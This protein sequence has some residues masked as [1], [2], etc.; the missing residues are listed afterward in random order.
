[1]T[2]FGIE[3]IAENWLFL[4][5]NALRKNVE[6]HGHKWDLDSFVK[7]M[8]NSGLQ[9]LPIAYVDKKGNVLFNESAQKFERP[10]EIES[11]LRERW[12]LE[13]D[14]IVVLL[15]RE[16]RELV[17]CAPDILVSKINATLKDSEK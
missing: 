6:G 15:T 9:K 2:N 13:G 17:Q 4:D 1:M 8:L 3:D 16:G 10:E 7:E 14:P 11:I 5:L 12:A